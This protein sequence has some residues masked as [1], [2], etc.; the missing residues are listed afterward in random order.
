MRDARTSLLVTLP[1]VALT[2]FGCGDSTAPGANG[3]LEIIASTSGEIIDRDPDG[4]SITL[5]G[6]RLGYSNGTARTAFDIAPGRHVV[7]LDGVTPNCLVVEAGERRVDVV[8]G[9]RVSVSFSVAC[10]PNI[11]SLRVTIETS[12]ADTDADGYSLILP[13]KGSVTL[14]LNGTVTIPSLRAGLRELR[15]ES[16][17]TNCTVSGL[18]PRAVFISFETTIETVFHIECVVSGRVRVTIH[19]SGSDQNLSGY[20][21]RMR[22]LPSTTFT[23]IQAP[24]NGTFLLDA[25]PTGLNQFNL[26][27]AA[28][29]CGI[30]PPTTVARTILAGETAEVEFEVTCSDGSQ[31]AFVSGDGNNTEIG[32]FR[33]SN[34]AEIQITKVAG[35]DYDPAWS[36]DGAEIAFSSERTG[37]GE[38]YVMK[39]NGS[40]QRRI[41]NTAG[42]DYRPA[43]SPDGRRIAFVSER[44]GI[45]EIYVMNSD[46]TNAVRLTSN[47]FDD[48]DPSWSPDGS[49]IAFYSNRAG[50]NAIWLMNA[51]G[52][53]PALLVANGV[54]RQPAWSPDG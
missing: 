47:L 7:K 37:D 54:D 22:P 27:G 10:A 51:D 53:S 30:A 41:T 1:I 46:G 50:T 3:T 20:L 39:S 29:N 26:T 19:A 40:D 18:Y 13:D 25:I 28:S 12:G 6:H 33:L 15:L 42:N 4:Y 24:A 9:K 16:V 49:R 45:A 2:S 11:G 34:G 36:P 48:G 31:L 5:D 52:S 14:P 23:E 38:I 32:L 35:R 44:N 43:W 21:F 17:A 8:A